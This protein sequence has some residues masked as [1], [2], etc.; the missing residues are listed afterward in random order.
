MKDAV[1]T[2][3]RTVAANNEVTAYE[4]VAADEVQKCVNHYFWT[5]SVSNEELELV[6][7]VLALKTPSCELRLGELE[8]WGVGYMRRNISFGSG[9]RLLAGDVVL[10]HNEDEHGDILATHR[11]WAPRLVHIGHIDEDDIDPL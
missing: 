9:R 2:V 7:R 4:L 11:V 1:S 5:K 3:L 8:K 10:S 6:M